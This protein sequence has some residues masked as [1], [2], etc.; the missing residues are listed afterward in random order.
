MRMDLERRDR[1]SKRSTRMDQPSDLAARITAPNRKT[2]LSED[3]ELGLIYRPGRHASVPWDLQPLEL[4]WMVGFRNRSFRRYGLP[5]ARSG[6]PILEVRLSGSCTRPF[7][8]D[9][10][11]IRS[12]I[13][14]GRIPLPGSWQSSKGSLTGGE[15]ILVRWRYA[16]SASGLITGWCRYDAWR[17]GWMYLRRY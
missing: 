3:D 9:Q 16:S 14:G 6:L 4:A 2:T 5:R 1:W 11:G 12:S 15:S 17:F 7:Y 13:G 10:Y 8:P